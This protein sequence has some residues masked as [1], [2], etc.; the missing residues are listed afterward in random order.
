MAGSPVQAR[1]ISAL[2]LSLAPAQFNEGYL[3]GYN[4]AIMAVAQKLDEWGNQTDSIL[5]R[6]AASDVRRMRKTNPKENPATPR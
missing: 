5:L 6:G 3:S 4:S 1:P 2:E